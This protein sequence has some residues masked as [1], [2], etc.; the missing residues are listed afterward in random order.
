MKNI[1]QTPDIYFLSC[2][3]G[4]STGAA[5]ALAPVNFQQRVH[6][7]RPDEYWSWKWPFGSEKRSFFS[8]QKRDVCF[9]LF[10]GSEVAQK[11]PVPSRPWRAPVLCRIHLWVLQFYWKLSQFTVPYDVHIC[12][13]ELVLSIQNLLANVVKLIT[14]ISLTR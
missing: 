6:C 13:I 7:T 14:V 10:W 9:F 4:G 1:F 2:R 8:Q 11:A 5:G 3:G 12:S